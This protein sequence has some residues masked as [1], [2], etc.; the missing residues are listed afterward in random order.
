MFGGA[1][2]ETATV[3]ASPQVNIGYDATT[4]GDLTTS[5]TLLY[6]L[7]HL[8]DGTADPNYTSTTQPADFAAVVTGNVYGGGDLAQVT[9]NTV[10]NLR[11]ANSSVDNIF[12]GGYRAMVVGSPHINVNMTN[13]KVEVEGS[14]NASSFWPF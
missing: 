9:G 7:T 10:V 2:G 1:K 14:L 13:G 3:T 6:D 8:S 11:K 12:G 4:M 5:G